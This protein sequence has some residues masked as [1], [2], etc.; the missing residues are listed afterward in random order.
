[1]GKY[2]YLCVLR[3]QRNGALSGKGPEQEKIP[4]SHFR[5]REPEKE[6]SN[7]CEITCSRKE[8]KIRITKD[9]DET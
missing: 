5:Q 6:S 9:V 7:Y 4:N 8:T 1:M 2:S 3:L